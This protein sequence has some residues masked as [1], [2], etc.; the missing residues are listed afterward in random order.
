MSFFGRA[1]R[2]DTV[3]TAPLAKNKALLAKHRDGGIDDVFKGDMFKGD[4]VGV[5]QKQFDARMAGR[6]C[7]D[8][9][10]RHGDGGG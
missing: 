10:A 3:G 6:G 7:F 1:T 8:R 4:V 5:V 9:R 2:S